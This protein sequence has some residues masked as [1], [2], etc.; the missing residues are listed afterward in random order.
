MFQ[1]FIEGK[2]IDETEVCFTEDSEQ[3][4][5][6]FIKGLEYI[7]DNYRNKVAHKDGI[8]IDAAAECRELMIQTQNLLWILMYLLI[9]E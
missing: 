7:K 2:D 8:L 9:E 3:N 6:I 5:L 4:R 1:T